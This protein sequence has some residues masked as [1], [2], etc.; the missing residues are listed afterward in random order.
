MIAKLND[1]LKA[2]EPLAI[3]IA[4]VGI[5]F[6][7]IQLKLS[8]DQDA[9]TV[10][11]RKK[12]EARQRQVI[13]GMVSSKDNAL[14]TELEVNGTVRGAD[15]TGEGWI[16]INNEV[17][18]LSCALGDETPLY[19]LAS[20]FSLMHSRWSDA[21]ITLE[22]PRQDDTKSVKEVRLHANL[23][24]RSTLRITN[25]FRLEISGNDL[26]GGKM[27]FSEPAS[28]DQVR[29]IRENLIGGT[30]IYFGSQAE[31]DKLAPEILRNNCFSQYEEAPWFQVSSDI[32]D[33]GAG[34]LDTFAGVNKKLAPL[35]KVCR[36]KALSEKDKAFSIP[37]PIEKSRD[38]CVVGNYSTYFIPE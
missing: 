6:A 4:V 37:S 23:L 11:D 26:T 14:R 32:G 24:Q 8:F 19:T 2:F 18:R 38:G 13:L 33:L 17:A 5:V 9:R 36:I 34:K 29:N 3:L 12:S 16:I 7:A 25:G 22:K 30:T 28:L 35:A 15:L 31:L 1:F 21:A 27:Y 20:N 10:E